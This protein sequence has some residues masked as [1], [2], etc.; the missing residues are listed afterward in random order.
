MV[1]SVTEL[2]KGFFTVRLLH[3]AMKDSVADSL[4]VQHI[5]YAVYHLPVVAKNEAGFGAYIAQQFQQGLDL[6][7]RGRAIRSHFDLRNMFFCPQE[8]D[9]SH[10]LRYF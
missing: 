10:R 2:E 4:L 3:A 5:A 1:G 9:C 6:L 7:F 8:V